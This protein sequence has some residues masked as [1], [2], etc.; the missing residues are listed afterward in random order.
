MSTR[1]GTR[2]RRGPTLP[3]GEQIPMQPVDKPILCSPYEE[4][5]EYWL[6]DPGTGEASRSPGRRPAGHWFRNE[7]MQQTQ[8]RRLFAEENWEALPHVNSL[9]EDVKRWRMSGYRNATNTTRNLLRHWWREDMVRRL[10]FCQIE[11]VERL[12][13]LPKFAWAA[14]VQASRRSLPKKD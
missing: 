5:S 11:A 12:F 2:R 6:Y 14:N 7:P 8:Q 1:N 13:I 4:P 9:R 10:F 3:Q